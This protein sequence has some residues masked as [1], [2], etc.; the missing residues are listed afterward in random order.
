VVRTRVGYAGGTLIDPTYH[1]MGDHTEALQVDYDP[2]RIGYG[3]LLDMFWLS[4][5]PTHPAWSTQ[6]RAAVW[7]ADD[8][9]REVAL[10]GGRRA[11][12]ERG[13]DL[14]TAIE[15]LGRFYRAEDYHQKYSLRRERAIADELLGRYAS[16]RRFVD[17]TAAARING[18]LGGYG[19]RAHLELLLPKLGLS[20]M[21]Q[22][23]LL[24][25]V[26]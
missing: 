1:H 20:S 8:A 25:R 14:A 11:A 17:S 12:R 22:S 19:G 13:A 5:D 9:Q 15:P 3:E 2:S 26:S 16:D 7:V 4:H 24:A 10:T 23:R 6:Y 18:Y 21:A